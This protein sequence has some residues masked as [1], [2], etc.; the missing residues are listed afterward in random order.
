MKTPTIS[1]WRGIADPVLGEIEYDARLEGFGWVEMLVKEKIP[2]PDGRLAFCW[3]V[4]PAAIKGPKTRDGKLPPLVTREEAVEW[5]KRCLEEHP[6]PEKSLKDY[7]K[8]LDYNLR[9]GERYNIP[10][11]RHLVEEKTESGEKL[12][13]VFLHI[14]YPT[15]LAFY[16]SGYVKLSQG[17]VE[18][19]KTCLRE[20]CSYGNG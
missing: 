13:Q 14:K 15:I 5:L 10:T 16:A 4:L 12:S 11:W 6:D 20:P 18:R 19:L 3:A 2:I 17:Q 9:Y 8:K 1:G 7:I